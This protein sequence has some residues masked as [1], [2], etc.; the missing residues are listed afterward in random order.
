MGGLGPRIVQRILRSRVLPLLTVLLLFSGLILSAGYLLWEA[1]VKQEISVF[2]N[3]IVQLSDADKTAGPI[4]TKQLLLSLYDGEDLSF[5]TKGDILKLSVPAPPVQI[6][7]LRAKVIGIETEGPLYKLFLV[8]ENA[9]VES[10]IFRGLEEQ[11]EGIG[12][13]QMTLMVRKER[14]LAVALKRGKSNP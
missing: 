10:D 5:L 9:D 11:E 4:P 6:E 1:R 3:L 2:G 13:M 12:P 8:P 14:L 7:D